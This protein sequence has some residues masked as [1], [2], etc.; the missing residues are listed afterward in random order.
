[1]THDHSMSLS[2]TRSQLWAL[3]PSDY[4]D[5]GYRDAAGLPRPEL[6]GEW[7]VAA[8]EQLL[9][10]HVTPAQLE[11]LVEVTRKAARSVNPRQ[12]IKVVL[13]TTPPSA[14]HAFVAACVA[15]LRHDD[16]VPVMLQHLA[17]ILRLLA[18]ESAVA[19]P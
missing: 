4:L 8:A 5:A 6:T 11:R 18:L 10:D 9:R 12:A 1:M 7:S 17:A 19:R 13:A 14:A 2:M 3:T 15:E 16:D